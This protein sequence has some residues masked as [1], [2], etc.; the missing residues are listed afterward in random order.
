MNFRVSPRVATE[1]RAPKIRRG[2]CPLPFLGGKRMREDGLA[3]GS[4]YTER[5]KMRHTR[6]GRRAAFKSGN[7]RARVSGSQIHP[8]RRLG[9][10][11]RKH[12]NGSKTNHHGW[13]RKRRTAV[14]S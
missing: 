4:V 10:T 1:A 12:L 2:F 13:N 6:L 14:K 3:W 9:K 11:K 7:A 8:G 5:N